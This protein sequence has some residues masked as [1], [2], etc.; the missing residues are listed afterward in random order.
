MWKN[1]DSIVIFFKGAWETLKTVF[2]S[3]FEWIKTYVIDPF[4][5]VWNG[6]VDGIRNA[7][8]TVRGLFG[9][10]T[11]TPSTGGRGSTQ[12]IGGGPDPSPDWSVPTPVT[13]PVD[14]GKYVPPVGVYQGPPR[15]GYEYATGGIAYNPQI[16]SLAEN[17][18]EMVLPL[19]K[20]SSLEK[21]TVNRLANI[22]VELDGRAILKA[23]GQPLADEIRIRNGLRT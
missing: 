12:V 19:S 18:P 10:S 9:Q 3:G 5:V 13:V 7:I 22:I 4:M 6:M 21:A 11:S 8:N 16:A 1:W 15:A 23:I 20:L 14:S 2:S 17:G